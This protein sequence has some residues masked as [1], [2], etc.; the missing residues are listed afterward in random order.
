M[1]AATPAVAPPKNPARLSFGST[2]RGQSNEIRA[3]EAEKMLKFKAEAE[4]QRKYVHT[5]DI[6]ST[7]STDEPPTALPPKLPPSSPSANSRS[8]WASQPAVPG[9]G[10]ACQ[11]GFGGDGSRGPDFGIF[12]GFAR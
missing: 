5:P 1:L 8:Q 7:T 9:V 2:G 6:I 4:E 10:E 12:L 11:A 3:E